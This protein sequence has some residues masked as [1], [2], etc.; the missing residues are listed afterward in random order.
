MDELTQEAISFSY[1]R[2]IGCRKRKSEYE[3]KII[4]AEEVKKLLANLKGFYCENPE[5]QT[6]LVQIAVPA[7]KVDQGAYFITYNDMVEKILIT[8]KPERG[9]RLFVANVQ[10]ARF[11]TGQRSRYKRVTSSQSYYIWQENDDYHYH[12][13]LDDGDWLDSSKVDKA[14]EWFLDKI[15]GKATCSYG[16]RDFSLRGFR[17]IGRILEY[18]PQD[19]IDRKSTRQNTSHDG[20]SRMPTTD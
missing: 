4:P 1:E 15:G 18:Q 12:L 14:F 10:Q 6:G 11:G 13:L 16:W 3:K 9:L 20:A 17:E 8:S 2:M 7:L 19:G 5:Y